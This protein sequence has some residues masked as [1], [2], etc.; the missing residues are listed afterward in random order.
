MPEED[1][2]QATPAQTDLN[3][4][5]DADTTGVVARTRRAPAQTIKML[6]VQL[7]GEP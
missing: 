1:T 7:T 3:D 4:S 6:K 5:D 2:T